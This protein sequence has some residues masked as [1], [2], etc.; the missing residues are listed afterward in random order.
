MN[1]TFDQSLEILR[2]Y[3]EKIEE[4]NET[5]FKLFLNVNK[6]GFKLTWLFISNGLY[7]EMLRKDV[8][9]HVSSK[10]VQQVLKPFIRPF[11]FKNE[12]LP[13]N[14]ISILDVIKEFLAELKDQDSWFA[15]YFVPSLKKPEHFL[16]SYAEPM[17][18]ILKEEVKVHRGE[19]EFDNCVKSVELMTLL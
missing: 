7:D 13:E 2:D 17:F 15:M 12:N 10:K 19:L 14:E 6:V 16:I 1:E 8:I 9:T 3:S 5:V 11:S 4:K 18:E